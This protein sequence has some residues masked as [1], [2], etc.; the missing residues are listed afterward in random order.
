[1]CFKGRCR[2]SKYVMR[3]QPATTNNMNKKGKFK[4]EPAEVPH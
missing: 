3:Q 2:V 4:S 1:V